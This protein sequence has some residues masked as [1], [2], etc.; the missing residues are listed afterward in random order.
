MR[1]TLPRSI[2]KHAILWTLAFTV[3]AV[4]RNYDQV[5]VGTEAISRP[6]CRSR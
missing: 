5:V 1:F 2:A 6:D 3:F 4:L